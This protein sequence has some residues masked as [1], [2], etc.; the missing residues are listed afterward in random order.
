[1]C[2]V[3]QVYVQTYSIALATLT[4]SAAPSTSRA[5]ICPSQEPTA[6][7]SLSPSSHPV[8]RLPGPPSRRPSPAPIS[9]SVAPTTS[10]N[11][12]SSAPSGSTGGAAAAPFSL[13]AFLTLN[14]II[15][16]SVGCF[17]LLLAAV[18]LRQ[19]CVSARRGSNRK[20]DPTVE[21]VGDKEVDKAESHGLGSSIDTE[22]VTVAFDW[23]YD[24][25]VS[26]ST[27]EYLAEP[28]IV[29]S[30]EIAASA[31]RYHR[32]SPPPRTRQ[33]SGRDSFSNQQ[34]RDV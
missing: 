24:C 31:N 12:P 5:P 33:E 21:G 3:D 11:A 34:E 29:S 19:Y 4:P 10:S 18:A 9:P 30:P 16:V 20:S 27:P 6:S 14:V 8:Y 23:L 17:V 22:P 26:T 28:R 32:R 15:F 1:M 2:I 7:P 25:A 13:P